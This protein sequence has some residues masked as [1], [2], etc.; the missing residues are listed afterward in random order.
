[1][2]MPSSSSKSQSCLFLVSLLVFVIAFHWIFYKFL[3]I[4]VLSCGAYH[5]CADICKRL[6]VMISLIVHTKKGSNDPNSQGP[7][8]SR[9]MRHTCAIISAENLEIFKLLVLS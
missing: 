5:K 8:H 4:F 1:L 2:L 6:C 7:K 9:Q 3:F